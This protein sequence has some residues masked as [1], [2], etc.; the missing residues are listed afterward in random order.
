MRKE[1]LACGHH[2]PMAPPTPRRG[3]QDSV[4]YGFQGTLR[5]TRR[6]VGRLRFVGATPLER[7][8]TVLLVFLVLLVILAFA[9]ALLLATVVFA[10]LLAVSV[11]LRALF[12]TR[13]Y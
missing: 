9:A 10:V 8:S 7:I 5:M 12:D 11:A 13:R 4:A 3:R 2:R 1:Q 6:R